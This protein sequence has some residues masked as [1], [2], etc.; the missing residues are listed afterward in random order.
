MPRRRSTSRPLD[1]EGEPTDK[2]A[3]L[4]ASEEE[5]SSGRH[6][7]PADLRLLRRR[8]HRPLHLGVCGPPARV[9]AAAG[10]EESFEAAMVAEM[11][12]MRAAYETRLREQEGRAREAEATLRRELRALQDERE[13]D[14]RAHEARLRALGVDAGAAAR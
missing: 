14:R 13:R 10:G 7:I 8:F 1:G 4:M 12:A 2:D 11:G 9:V 6:R 3:R 5:N